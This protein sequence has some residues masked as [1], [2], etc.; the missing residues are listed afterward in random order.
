M[1]KLNQ[2]T[3]IS[4]LKNSDHIICIVN[5]VVYRVPVSFFRQDGYKGK[6]IT[7][8]NPGVPAVGDK[9]LCDVDGVYANFGGQQAY[10]HDWF[11]WNGVSWDLE[12]YTNLLED[13]YQGVVEPADAAPGN[14]EN[15]H[16]VKCGSNGVYANFSN[17]T[18]VGGD[19]LS[20][21]SGT[22]QWKKS[23]TYNFTIVTL[24]NNMNAAGNKITNLPVGSADGDSINYKQHLEA[25]ALGI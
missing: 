22:G 9:W 23:T 14:L 19:V 4:E 15:G 1:G 12:Q 7:T 8:T 3:I 24:T 2:E 18:A 17:T 10:K 5:D 25:I 16:W 11:H 13:L 6:A 21:N 20:Y